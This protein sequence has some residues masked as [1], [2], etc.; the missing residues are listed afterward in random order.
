MKLERFVGETLKQIINGV[1]SAK[2]Y[3]EQHGALINPVNA[4]FNTNSQNMI[5]CLETGIPLQHVEFDVAVT[6]CESTTS[7][8]GDNE[9]VGDITVS[10]ASSESNST[11]SSVSRIKFSVPVRLPTSGQKK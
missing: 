6:V 11:N 1:L 3:G 4:R 8:S 7:T 10:G 5:Y 9:A 2:D